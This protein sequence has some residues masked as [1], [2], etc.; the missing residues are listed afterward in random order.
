MKPLE[1]IKELHKQNIKISESKGKLLVDVPLGKLSEEY[2]MLIRK[3]KNELVSLLS[4]MKSFQSSISENSK[5]TK[6]IF[7][8]DENIKLSF[9]QQR[10]WF[11]D[12]LEGGS[13]E[14]NMPVALRIEGAFS[15]T[16][17][18]QA[19][20]RIIARHEPLRTVF[21]TRESEP[22]QVIRES[23]DFQLKEYDLCHLS[24]DTQQARISELVKEDSTKVFDLQTDVMVRASYL[25]L[26]FAGKAQQNSELADDEAF[27]SAPVGILLFSMHHIA[28]D[29]WSV[30][31]LVKE[32][33]A[34]YQAILENKPSPFA[35]LAIQ[36]ADYAHWQREWLQ[37]EVLEGQL[38]YWRAQLSDIPMVHSLPLS[39]PRP[40][41]KTHGGKLVSTH[42]SA[43]VSQRINKIALENGVTQFML[44]HAALGL[45]LSRHSNSHDIVIGTPVANR[46]RAELEPLIGF[47][48]NTLVLRTNTQHDTFLE[49]LAHVKDVNLY[50]Q[51]NQDVPFEQL[52]EHFNFKRSL[53]HTSLFQ[54]MF[55]MN[56]NESGELKLPG[57][58]LAPVAEGEVLAKFD[59][60]ISAEVNN[61]GIVFSWLYD[62]SI[63]SEEYVKTL[64]EHLE[65]IVIGIADNY[66]AMLHDLPM[67]SESELHHL[68]HELNENKV[69]YANDK[70]IHELF[71]E[72]ARTQPNNIALKFEETELSY[73]ALNDASNRLAHYLRGKGVGVDSLVGLCLDS[74][75]EMVVGILG[76]L[77]AG[78]AY[79]PLDPSYPEAR[80]HYMLEDTG[81][82]WLL[83]QSG[84]TEPLELSSEIDVILLDTAAHADEM[85]SYSGDNIGCIDERSASNLAYVIYTSGSTGQPKGVMVEHRSLLHST[86]NRLS[87]YGNISVFLLLS[88]YAFDSSVAGVFHTLSSG[89]KLCLVEDLQDSISIIKKI[90]NENVSHILTAPSYYNMFL[91][92]IPDTDHSKLRAVVVAG[93]VFN[94][95]LVERH[96]HKLKTTKLYNEY[97]PTEGTVW[98][99]YKLLSME[100]KVSIGRPIDNSKLYVGN[101]DCQL[102]PV[103]TIGELFIGGAG[104]ARGYLNRPE[105]TAER[106]IPNPFSDNP[107]ERLYKS[108]DLVRYLPD[109]NLEFIGRIDEQVKIRGFRIELGEIAHQLS[110][111]EGVTSSVVLVR[112]DEPGDKRIVAYVVTIDGEGVTSSERV[113]RLRQQLQQTLPDYMLPSAF[114]ILEALPLTTNGKVDKKALHAPDATLLQDEYIAPVTETEK[115]LVQ[116]WAKLLKFDS[117]AISVT[118]N[119]FELGGDSLLIIRLI[120]EIDQCGFL[121]GE[122]ISV[123]SVFENSILNSMSAYI[124]IL[125]VRETNKQ[126]DMHLNNLDSIEIGEL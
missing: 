119:F 42:L 49:Y 1:I 12:Q 23:V 122:K 99:T 15:V 90:S 46:M 33:V 69:D 114:V 71:E 96:F 27:D 14:Y 83:S 44:L 110:L 93:E 64:S 35:P 8:N 108:G 52:V 75:I 17:A 55:S 77:K 53:Q 4:E 63:F 21:E 60:D 66:T 51:A 34:Q 106:F 45:V 91:D 31:V 25:R 85:E 89:G 109:S 24:G 124:D 79:V 65:R 26:S 72:Q 95:S 86:L 47:F 105:L 43:Q 81:V 54:I 100:D 120:A 29:G 123:K 84:V 58:T 32:F 97:G 82:K 48:V 39:Y 104:L 20:S 37:G 76:I 94:S 101:S 92:L 78:G 28:S 115:I 103:G 36:Y 68:T 19:I 113:S 5:I 118:A 117:E 18:E 2:S 22:V 56:T 88:S 67:L 98:S 16:A 11:I 73:G 9:A 62:S 6:K 125:V 3:H 59:L 41:I 61:E 121:I 87:T 13:P 116:I 102:V 111:C 30:G 112:E 70:L 40:K 126:T 38:S 50:A 10:L 74:S 80:L 57:L 107:E 7:I